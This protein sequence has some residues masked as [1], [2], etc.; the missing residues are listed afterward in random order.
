MPE[1]STALTLPVITLQSVVLPGATL[2]IDLDDPIMRAAVE[3]ARREADG[4]IAISPP[5][6]TDDTPIGVIAHVPN[7]GQL[8]T[9]PP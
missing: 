4:R 8:P 9:V 3:H 2:T 6:P 1:L 7:V 5:G